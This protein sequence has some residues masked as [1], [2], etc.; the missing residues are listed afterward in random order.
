MYITSY[1]FTK[2]MTTS[3]SVG[4][5]WNMLE[6]MVQRNRTIYL[7]YEECDLHQLPVRP[8]LRPNKTKPTGTVRACVRVCV[9]YINRTSVE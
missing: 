5:Y 1:I 4:I 3:D 9:V 7:S 2:A 6:K 8:P